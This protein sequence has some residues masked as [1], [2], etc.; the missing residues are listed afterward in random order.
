MSTD[1]EALA[2]KVQLIEDWPQPGAAFCDLTSL[3]ADARSFHAVI[4]AIA[5]HFATGIADAGGPPVDLVVGV[6]ARGYAVAAPVALRL[7]AGFVPV[8]R[9]GRLPPSVVAEEYAMEFGSDLLEVH[10]AS[11]GSAHRVLVVDDVLG[12]GAT[13][14]AVVRLVRSLGAEVA[15]FACA[16]ELAGHGGRDALGGIEVF[17][18]VTI[19]GSG[20]AW[21]TPGVGGAGAVGGV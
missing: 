13:A 3:L 7:D 4:T 2:S 18:A 1:R 12:T 16:V 10:A 19:D 5:D 20:A 21:R 15:G 14:A 9:A 6:E 8:R 11:V 17:S